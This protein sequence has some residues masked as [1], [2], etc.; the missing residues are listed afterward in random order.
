[1]CSENFIQP[2]TDSIA[3]QT[4]IY[5]AHEYRT[6]TLGGI[7]PMAFEMFQVNV[8]AIYL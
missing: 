2:L 7:L 3:L 4:L 1:M 6:R 5:L 8:D